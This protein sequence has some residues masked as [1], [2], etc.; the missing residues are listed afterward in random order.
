MLVPD[1]FLGHV[2]A[3]VEQ[4][5]YDGETGLVIIAGGPTSVL[6]PLDVAL[7]K[8]FKD[9]VNEHYHELVLGDNLI[10]PTGR[11]RRSSLLTVAPLTVLKVFPEEMMCK[12]FR[13]C[14]IGKPLNGRV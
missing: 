9:P 4:S 13:E 5:L 3:N 6:Q 8:L 10:T 14:S 2:T 1:S 12:S 7:N 11:L